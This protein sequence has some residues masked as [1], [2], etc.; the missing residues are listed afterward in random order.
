MLSVEEMFVQ[1]MSKQFEEEA[2]ST[3]ERMTR[4]KRKD[5]MQEV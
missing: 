5:S 4:S 3:S 2:R 1:K